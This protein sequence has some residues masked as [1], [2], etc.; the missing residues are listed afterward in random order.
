MADSEL[1]LNSKN[2]SAFFLIHITVVARFWKWSSADNL[3][4]ECSTKRLLIAL[5]QLHRW[6]SIV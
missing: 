2:R 5:K 3:G 1:N 6:L 4:N